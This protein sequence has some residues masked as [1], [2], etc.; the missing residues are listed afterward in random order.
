M[1][2]KNC[3][4]EKVGRCFQSTGHIAGSRSAV[5]KSLISNTC[6]T[7]NDVSIEQIGITED[8]DISALQF[9]PRDLHVEMSQ[10]MVD[11]NM[12]NSSQ[13]IKAF[14]F[15]M[16][17]VQS[18]HLHD[19]CSISSIIPEHLTSTREGEISYHALKW[20]YVEK[21][22]KLDTVF[23]TNY[24]GPY[25]FEEL[26]TFWATDLLMVRSIWSRGRPYDS[27][28]SVSFRKLQAIHMYRCP[29]LTFVLSLSWS[30]TLSSTPA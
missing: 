28:D 14:Y 12:A 19:N 7:Y 18:L 26:E 10:E 5:H 8:D 6:N 4:S 30:H 11:I 27:V 23:H 15:V 24:D 2:Q 16:D 22:P 21:C 13:G 29:M 9:E 25:L 20:C 3:N 17:R 1:M